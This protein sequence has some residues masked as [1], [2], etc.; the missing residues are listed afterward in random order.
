MEY[1]LTNKGNELWSH[2]QARSNAYCYVREANLKSDIQ[3]DSNY[4]MFWKSQNYGD[5]KKGSV[6]ARGGAGREGGM[7]GWSAAEFRALK[8]FSVILTYTQGS[9]ALYICQNPYNST[10]Q[11]FSANVNYRHQ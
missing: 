5:I 4:I 8:L 10:T 3:C 9:M 11:K 1:Y 6:I 2:E 7:N